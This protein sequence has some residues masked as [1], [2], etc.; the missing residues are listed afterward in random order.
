MTIGW[1][2]R[3]TCR[4]AAE[5]ATSIVCALPPMPSRQ[6]TRITVEPVVPARDER[7]VR[8]RR[9]AD[10]RREQRGERLL[11]LRGTGRLADLEQPGKLV[12]ELVTALE[13]ARVL[14]RHGGL[15]GQDLDQT[16]IIVVEAAD[17]P[18]R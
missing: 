11:I 7:A 4:R 15:V 13:Q 9:L 16:Q 2:S 3:S 8:V 17:R 18:V 12:D 6:M 1:P 10:A 5:S 14:D